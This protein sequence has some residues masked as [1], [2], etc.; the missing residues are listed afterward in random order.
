MRSTMAKFQQIL[1][2]VAFF[3]G[4]AVSNAQVYYFDDFESYD[5]GKNVTQI[6][7]MYALRAYSE[8]EYL[9]TIVGEKYGI[10]PYSGNKMVEVRS[11]SVGGQRAIY[12]NAIQPGTNEISECNIRFCVPSLDQ[13]SQR[14]IFNIF[15]P[16]QSVLTTLSVAED[17][18]RIGSI[19][20]SGP[21][22]LS[23]DTWH[24]FTARFDWES[25]EFELYLD[26]AL[27]YQNSLAVSPGRH[28]VRFEFG[29][30]QPQRLLS[31]FPIAVGS[32]GVLYDNYEV[33]AV[34]DPATLLT[35]AAGI[36]GIAV[37][38]QRRSHK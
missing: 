35:L 11:A 12:Q 36:A 20:P 25:K 8:G 19:G 4:V 17:L 28:V 38:K 21:V 9:P 3:G 27:Y 2:L 5:I 33:E 37:P 32:P 24:N 1:S 30:D 34:P 16:D 22:N 14:A 13:R 18:F 23:F 7:P 26:G 10:Q 15:T 31:E 29:T 6:R